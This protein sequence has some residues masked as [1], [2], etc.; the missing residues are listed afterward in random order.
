LSDIPEPIRAEVHRRDKDRCVRCGLSANHVHHRKLRSAGGRHTLANLIL[1]CHR[2]HTWVHGH[3][4]LARVDGW[5]LSRYTADP[6]TEPVRYG[7]PG[8]E[9]RHLL[10]DI[11]GWDPE[12]A[13]Q[14]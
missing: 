1:L 14:E 9:G 11:H 13:V 5:I 3:V 7:Q 12:L 6:A 10:A 4:V 8:R 2:C